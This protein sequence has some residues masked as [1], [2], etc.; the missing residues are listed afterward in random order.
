MAD[1][2]EGM[3]I[4]AAERLLGFHDAYTKAELSSAYRKA[5]KDNHPDFAKSD[6]DKEARTRRS[7]A[8]NNAYRKLMPLF[9]GK[10]AGYRMSCSP[11]KSTTTNAADTT[12]A[13]TD[14]SHATTAS[15]SAAY[16][17]E[18][19]S[20]H[21]WSQD[22]TA[23][24][25]DTAG[26]ATGSRSHT[27]SRTNGDAQRNQAN[28]GGGNDSKGSRK[29]ATTKA[30]KSQGTSSRPTTKSAYA[31]TDD[32]YDEFMRRAAAYAATNPVHVSSS[33]GQAQPAS[34]TAAPAPAPDPKLVAQ[35]LRKIRLEKAMPEWME[36][37]D[38]V[39][40]AIR[41]V[42]LVVFVALGFFGGP[43]GMPSA[44]ANAGFIALV[45][46]GFSGIIS[47][48]TFKWIASR[49]VGRALDLSEE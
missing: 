4:S 14:T 26:A 20:Y 34:Q 44:V 2:D 30:R 25:T 5:I 41:T 33:Q 43:L 23:T 37:N 18:W 13:A 11:E 12:H 27:K 38:G 28:G 45:V 22:E 32:P 35:R 9:S 15:S 3:D 42:M 48:S 19:T 8:I 29:G 46:E 10:P 17:Y 40:R 49:V 31:Q 24:A 7:A 47:R 16:Q 6:A 21:P 1:T 39:R 36:R